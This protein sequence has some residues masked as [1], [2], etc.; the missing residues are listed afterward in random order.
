MFKT[1]DIDDIVET[2]K[3]AKDR[4]RGCVLLIG[5]GCSVTGGI[6]PASGIMDHIQEHYERAYKRAEEKRY[7]ICMAELSKDERRDLIAHYVDEA[8]INWA[9]VCIAQ[10]L[11]RGY[12]DRI[13]T[14]NFDPLIVRACALIGLFPAVYDFAASQAFEAGNI[15]GQAVVHLHGQRSGFVL[16]N[17]QAEVEGHVQLLKPVFDEAGQGRVWLVVGYSGE[18]DPVFDR[19]AE[20][21][22]FNNNLYWVGY[23]DSPPA[24]HVKEKL[25]YADKDAF[26]VNG[27]DADSFF[28]SLL[29]K[30]ECFPP[31]F[32]GRP[33]SYLDQLM[34]K[35]S[36][37]AEPGEMRGPDVIGGALTTIRAAID[38]FEKAKAAAR[39]RDAQDKLMAGKFDE[40]EV[41]RPDDEALT[42]ELR[43]SLAWAEVLKGK[44]LADQAT[45][46]TG[47]EADS[48]F[49]AAY[50]KFTLALA[51]EPALQEA[52]LNWG[53]AFSTQA[54]MKTGEEAD[55]L[56]DAAYAKYKA[57][58][59]REPQ[60]HLALYNLGNALADQAR[61]KTGTEA[62]ELFDAAYGNYEAALAL[63]PDYH[64][65]SWNLG[66]ALYDQAKT[67]TGAEHDRLLEQAEQK[68]VQTGRVYDLAC[69]S[70][71]QGD[72]DAARKLMEC[73]A[74]AGFQPDDSDLDEHPELAELRVPTSWAD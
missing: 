42:P 10:L 56:F 16:L 3:M 27:Y 71:R 1:R 21:S 31:D 52:L 25:L 32:I 64:P 37:F 48:L 17:T 58:L 29:R 2:L 13:L 44:D 43:S 35:L 8:K 57:V 73:A 53:N 23:R 62:N 24:R 18:S 68:V 38:Q 72:V 41:V 66:L 6:P 65:A 67:K 34:Q 69:A 7:P 5:A 36:P 11:E 61:T 28:I 4:G 60:D 15:P 40:V 19:L 30:L 54:T 20:F 14:T 45:T 55:E 39:A 49:D 46:K 12:V 70:A 9:H 63:D 59:E 51:L 26:Y 33:F 47:A 22:G 74:K 50:A